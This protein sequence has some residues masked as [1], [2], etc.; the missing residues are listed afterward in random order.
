MKKSSKKIAEN[1]LKTA[2]RQVTSS[3][4]SR[5]IDEVLDSWTPG[6]SK[7]SEIIF[8]TLLQDFPKLKKE[9][10]ERMKRTD[11][12]KTI[13][14][15]GYVKKFEK[16]RAEL[17]R[18]EPEL[19][20]FN[21]AVNSAMKNLS[22]VPREKTGRLLR[23]GLIKLSNIL[24]DELFFITE[25]EKRKSRLTPD[26]KNALKIIKGINRKQLKDVSAV[27]KILDS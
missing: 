19:N 6:S 15:D 24:S 1:L 16:D 27:L 3:G 9:I 5:T 25:I 4:I 22:G 12:Y 26:Q 2:G 11:Q 10:A 13:F 14:I 21:N 23:A 8:R 20:E 18:L 7:H 17:F